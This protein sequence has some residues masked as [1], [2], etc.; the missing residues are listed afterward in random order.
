MSMILNTAQARQLREDLAELRAYRELGMTP[1]KIKDLLFPPDADA[2]LPLNLGEDDIHAAAG[3][4]E[5]W[6]DPANQAQGRREAEQ[7]DK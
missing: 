2:P 4:L 5:D 7:W 1:D 6:E 3:I